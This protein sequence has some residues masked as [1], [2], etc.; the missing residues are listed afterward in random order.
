M[1][2]SNF[3]FLK[4]FY[5]LEILFPAI[6]LSYF[7]EPLYFSKPRIWAED[8]TIYLNNAINN[9]FWNI[10]D[11]SNTGQSEI[12]YY[13]FYTNLISHI[14]A[15][16][17]P[18]KYAAHVNTYASFLFQIFTCIVIYNS[19]YHLF[20]N[21]YI[22]IF[23]ALSPIFLC[24]PEI[25]L[26]LISVQFW[27]TTGMIFIL[28]TKKQN[29]LNIL[30]SF[31]A[32]FTGSG[33]LFI[34]PFF[35]LKIKKNKK[36]DSILNIISFIGISAFVVQVISFLESDADSLRFQLDFLTTLLLLKILK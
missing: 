23:I 20:K 1:K 9:S 8:G 30:Y 12:N 32:F 29:L 34:L 13:S 25:W 11:P 4:N 17:F 14:S 28:N 3:N 35:I 22:C 21:K 27:G 19:I 7:R 16:I 24:S 10:F 31:L 18:I 5:F 26:S 15:N 36:K 33:S 2:L 6:I